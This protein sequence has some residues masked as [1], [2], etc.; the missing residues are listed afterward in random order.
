[1]VLLNRALVDHMILLPTC[2]KDILCTGRQMGSIMALLS[3]MVY[4]LREQVLER[5][6]IG[7]KWV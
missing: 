6:N 2:M 5:I 4:S 1:M 3:L 7:L